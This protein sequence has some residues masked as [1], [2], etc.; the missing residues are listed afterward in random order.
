MSS[1]R[2]ENLSGIRTAD[3]QLNSPFR[4][5]RMVEKGIHL[6]RN[7]NGPLTAEL[8]RTPGKFGLGQVPEKLAPDK[9]TNLICGYCS[10]GCNLQAH[11]K[12]D[13]AI[14]L[15]ADTGYPVNLGMGCPKGWEALAP[16]TAQNRATKPLLDGKE[17]WKEKFIA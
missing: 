4:F 8:S 13:A 16:L 10:T 9:I 6:L 11:Q 2:I 17:I 5:N 12:G 14:N 7:W 15:T 1:P 3:K